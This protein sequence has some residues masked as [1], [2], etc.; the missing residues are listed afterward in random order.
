[1]QGKSGRGNTSDIAIQIKNDDL[2]LFRS[3]KK[4][5][6]KINNRPSKNKKPA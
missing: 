1:L 2:C 6:S 4:A 3:G 5:V